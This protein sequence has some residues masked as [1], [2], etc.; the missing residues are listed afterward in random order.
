MSRDTSR[1]PS[2]LA[3]GAQQLLSAVVLIYSAQLFT[4]LECSLL[5]CHSCS[6]DRKGLQGFIWIPGAEQRAQG[7]AV[8]AAAF[9]SQQFS[10]AMLDAPALPCASRSVTPPV[11]RLP[12]A[13]MVAFNWQALENFPLLMYI[14][15]AKTLILCLAFAGVKMYQSNKIEEKLKREREEKLKAEAEKK[16][17]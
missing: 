6:M 9:S 14:L 1:V 11:L 12:T 8:Y 13:E 7:S 3:L 2:S 10:S 15:A 5:L 17:E 4:V 16:D